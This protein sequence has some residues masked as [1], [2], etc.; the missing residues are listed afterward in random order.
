MNPSQQFLYDDILLFSEMKLQVKTCS[1]VR[2]AKAIGRYAL[3]KDMPKLFEKTYNSKPVDKNL[4]RFFTNYEAPH[5]TFPKRDFFKI[6]D[7]VLTMDLMK[8]LFLR[9]RQLFERVSIERKMRCLMEFKGTTQYDVVRELLKANGDIIFFK[10]RKSLR[11]ESVL[12]GKVDESKQLTVT[13]VSRN[14]V[15]INL[16]LPDIRVANKEI[17][18]LKIRVLVANNQWSESTIKPLHTYTNK[19]YI[20]GAVILDSDNLWQDYIT[21]LEEDLNKHSLSD[22]RTNQEIRRIG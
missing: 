7:P 19:N 11:Y 10:S 2:G 3:V 9:D 22:I 20:T 16:A 8:A 15:S 18:P 12:T 13:S 1:F 5:L 21:Y 4:Y 14:G 6:T 17:V